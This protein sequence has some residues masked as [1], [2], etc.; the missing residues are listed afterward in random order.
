MIIIFIV[1]VIMSIY[2][3]RRK[4]VSGKD[5]SRYIHAHTHTYTQ[6]QAQRRIL[7]VIIQ[8]YLQPTET[9]NKQ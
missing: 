1:L 8:I 7:T 5:Y 4:I 2:N 9:F 3:F 6:A